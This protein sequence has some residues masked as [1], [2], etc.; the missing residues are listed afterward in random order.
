MISLTNGLFP[1]LTDLARELRY[2][3]FDQPLFEGVRRQIYDQ[4]ENHLAYMAAH[5]D[6]EDR[7]ARI[8]ALVECPQPLVSL[9]SNCFAKADQA[10]RRLMLEALTWRYYRIRQL[11]NFRCVALDDKQCCATAEYDYEGKRLHLFTTHGELFRLA[12]AVR[13]LFPM[14]AEVPEDHDILIDFYVSHFAA[15]SDPDALQQEVASIINQ[16][17]FPRPIRRIVTSIT[18]PAH[19]HDVGS[20]QHFTYRPSANGYQE[21]K[22]FRGIHPMMGKRLHLWR[23]DNFNIDRLPSVEDVYLLHAVA[24]DNPKDERLFACAEVRDLT[25]VRDESGR[26]VQLPHLERM[27]TEALAGNTAISIAAT[28]PS[29]P[30]LESYFAECLA[31]A[32][33]RSR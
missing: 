13:N 20:T 28:G 26:I 24:R 7:P 21:E 32:H 10:T 6:D 16:A 1:A 5:P 11:S 22:F 14:I 8:R 2:R 23:L 29:A 4:M 9:F 12:E 27:F 18:G 31:T 19:N 33:P 17:G 25:P 15:A 30:L 3:R